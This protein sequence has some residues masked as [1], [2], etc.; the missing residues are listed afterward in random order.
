MCP[1]KMYIK[2]FFYI[3]LSHTHAPES[4]SFVHHQRLRTA[5]D[6]TQAT[7]EPEKALS[8]RPTTK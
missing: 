6:S 7:D 1:K 2:Y 5:V 8:I 4:S 3:L